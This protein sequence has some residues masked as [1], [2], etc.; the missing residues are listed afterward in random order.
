MELT[1]GHL[2]GGRLR[3]A[4]PRD[5]YRS[6]IEPVLLAASVPA[7]PGQRVLEAGTGAGAGLLCL[8]A[9]VPGLTGFG[10]EID[11]AMAE[12]ARQNLRDN[13]IA[14]FEI[15]AGDIESLALG[16]FDHAFANPPWHDPHSTGSPVERRRQAKQER[17]GGLERWIAAIG[18]ML[19]PGGSLTL[20]LPPG[21]LDRAR[22]A[23]AAFAGLNARELLPKRGRAPKL[24]I[25]QA[26]W[27][28]EQPASTLPP[29]VLHEADGAFTPEIEA[30]LRRG[31]GLR[32]CRP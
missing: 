23:A 32:A 4:Q 14:G 27:G 25:V 26:W 13:G 15:V 7:R 31:E 16:P 9:R 21:Q 1:H 19:A 11:P 28:V 8:G 5:G 2:L 18:R 12:L 20:I 22:A 6:G 3:Y 10:V 30:V 29:A 24:A 17:G